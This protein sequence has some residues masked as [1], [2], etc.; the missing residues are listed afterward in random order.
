M[1]VLVGMTRFA[2]F[3]FYCLSILLVV[4]PPTIRA[5]A[6]QDDSAVLAVLSS[7]QYN[8]ESDGREFLLGEAKANDFFLLGELHGENE[9][10]ELLRALWPQMWKDGYRH[11]AAEV[12][13][14]AAH[15]LEDVPPG[16]G[17]DVVTLW[18]KK[19]A[20]DIHAFAGLGTNVLWGCDMEEV[21]PQ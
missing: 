10:P 16:Q 1:R 5:Q 21:Q 20:K 8:L 4:C 6:A 15:Q 11:V 7:H 13:P 9:I 3:P 2:I 12:S 19:Q 17:P 14:W 18:S